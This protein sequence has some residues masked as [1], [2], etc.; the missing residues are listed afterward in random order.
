MKAT[1]SDLSL[2]AMA[3][4]DKAK[5]DRAHALTVANVDRRLADTFDEQATRAEALATAAEDGELET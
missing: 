2:I 4:R 5:A 3:L 1:D